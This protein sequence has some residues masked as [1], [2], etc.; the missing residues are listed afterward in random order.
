MAISAYVGTSQAL[1]GREASTQA[2]HR[3]LEQ[4]G[5]P[6]LDQAVRHLDD[7]EDVVRRAVVEQQ[8]PRHATD[9]SRRPT[10]LQ[11]WSDPG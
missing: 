6:L 2:A 10:A 4:V 9:V 3:A 11:L 8:H 7:L 1:Y 5:R